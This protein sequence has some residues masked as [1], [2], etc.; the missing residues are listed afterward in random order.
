[1]RHPKA[2]ALRPIWD[3]PGYEDLSFLSDEDRDL[4]VLFA[5]LVGERIPLDCS[6]SGMWGSI[7]PDGQEAHKRLIA[8]G[9]LR[10]ATA[11][12]LFMCATVSEI[13][14]LLLSAGVSFMKSWKK[15]K[16]IELAR[17]VTGPLIQQFER[18]H[19]R[20][21]PSH[22]GMMLL[23][24][25]YT[26]RLRFDARVYDCI[27]RGDYAAAVMFWDQ[28]ND[29]QPVP[30]LALNMSSSGSC[31]DHV[32]FLVSSMGLSDSIPDRHESYALY[33]KITQGYFDQAMLDDFIQSHKSEW[34]V[35]DHSLRHIIPKR[36]MR[37][38]QQLAFDR[39]K[40]EL[41]RYRDS[42]VE[43]YM[44]ISVMDAHT[45]ERCAAC[46]GKLYSVSDAIIGVNFPPF[47][48]GCRCSTGPAISDEWVSTLERTVIDPVTGWTERIPVSG[49][50]KWWLEHYRK[51]VKTGSSK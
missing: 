51:P 35:E 39:S 31:W 19:W 7:Y 9:C 40:D 20:Y 13:Q 10:K 1:M 47:H 28:Y 27:Q 23:R 14:Q 50:Y 49:S 41:R 24:T 18:A 4:V 48:D 16:L 8:L 17:G 30:N 11:D 15:Q 45:C 29:A 5:H 38:A 37:N 46:D 44:I 12:E 21:L 33:E 3:V 25:L 36:K 34:I 2:A 6:I 42:S 22:K 32:E 26:V 43:K